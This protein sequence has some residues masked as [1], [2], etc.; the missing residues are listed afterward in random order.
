MILVYKIVFILTAFS[1]GFIGIDLL[2]K[3]EGRNFFERIFGLMSV[4][5]V[6]WAGG[7]FGLLSASTEEAALNWAHLL[8]NGS[9]LVH[10][11]FLH[12]ILIFL[13]VNRERFNRFIVRFFYALGAILLVLNNLYFITGQSFLV[14]GVASKLGFN[15]FEVPDVFYLLHVLNYLFIPVYSVALMIFEFLKSV[16]ERRKQIALVM[17][18]ALVGF[19]GGNSVVPLVFNIQI[20]PLLL[21][22]V[23]FYMPILTYAIIKHKL[24]NLKI[25]T[26]EIFVFSLWVFILV[27]IFLSE[28]TQE[29]LFNAG[30]LVLT[31]VVGIFLL[32]SV[33]REVKQREKIESLAKDLERANDSLESANERLKELD[34][35][36]SEFVSLA[37]HQIR[38]PLTAIKGYAS[39]ITEGD[40]GE[41]PEYLKKPIDI[42]FQSCQS[43]VVI[44]EDFLNIS[45][46]EQGR[47]KYEMTIFDMGGLVKEVVNEFRPNIEKKGL[48]VKTEIAE[49][50]S[51]N[52]DRGKIK[53][54]ISNLLD[55][56]V[57]YTP[58]GEITISL[59]QSGDKALFSVKDTGLGIPAATMPKLFQKFSRAE[60]AAK[61]N[62]HGTGLGLYVAREMM[63]ALG[64]RV[65]A[66][67]EGEGKGSAFF[68]ELGLAKNL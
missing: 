46:I 68:V 3:K 21:V 62:I 4:A 50:V 16:G 34:Q 1:A 56:S 43:L 45:R 61:A 59:S 55:N 12:T 30:L 39:E 42:I 29:Q 37:T 48:A 10:I 36:K 15:F 52:A 24:F 13:G 67:S 18:A 38:G 54:V 20:E 17:L 63:K 60:E 64:G 28:N 66:E 6:I 7:R 57:K 53:Q 51:V 40:F 65:W 9:I 33:Y 41:L 23:P 35:L 31:I 49:G 5:F 44:V 58:K 32:R 19:I 47:M 27:R 2:V 8:Y 26:S 14:S 11:L 25:I 22:L